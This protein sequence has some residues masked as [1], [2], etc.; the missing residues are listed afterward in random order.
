MEYTIQQTRHIFVHK[1]L[2][3]ILEERYLIK[4]GLIMSY[5]VGAV[6]KILSRLGFESVF[7]EDILGRDY[8]KMGTVSY[9]RSILCSVLIDAQDNFNEYYTFIRFINDFGYFMSQIFIDKIKIYTD[10]TEF[11]MDK[12]SGIVSGIV[13]I[14]I[15]PIYDTEIDTSHFEYMYH[16]T[17]DLA[18]PMILKKG[19]SFKS[20]RKLSK[21]PDRIYLAVTKDS[22]IYLA[23]MFEDLELGSGFILLKVKVPRN[24]YFKCF[25][26]QNV[27]NALYTYSHIHSSNISEV[28]LQS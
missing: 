27:S 2:P 11:E 3:E 22:A 16:V 1:I 21:H 7:M 19:L 14:L 4:K 10:H 24:S 12:N 13:K 17:S 9:N 8:F 23:E 6:C 20:K 28:N 26:D 5:R 18:L 25:I 15:E